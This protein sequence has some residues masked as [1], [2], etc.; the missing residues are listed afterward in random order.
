M[1]RFFHAALAGAG[2]CVVLVGDTACIRDTDCGICDPDNLIVESI[3]G[4][5][6]ASKKVHLLGPD[7]EGD[8]CPGDIKS[9]HYFVEEIKPCEDTDEAKE[10]GRPDEYCKVWPLAVTFGVEFIFN[11]LL[12]PTSVELVRKRPDQPKLFEVYDWKPDVVDIVGPTTRYNGDF[13]KGASEEPDL[14]TRLVNLACVDNLREAGIDFGAVQNQDPVNNPCNAV[15]DV[16]GKLVP[17]KM[18]VD[19]PDAKLQ[20]YKG[21]WTA[22]T[23]SCDT[24]QDGADT[25]CSEC[26]FLLGVRVAKYGLD[27]AGNPRDVNAGT[28]I[29]CDATEGDSLVDCRNF[30]PSVDR[31]EED[32]TYKYAWADGAVQEWKIAKSDKIRETHPDDRPEGFENFDAPC[33]EDA[34]CR[35]VHELPGTVCIGQKN[36][37]A[38]RADFDEECVENRVCRAEWFV[39]CKQDPNTTGGM[40]G[41]CVDRRFSDAGAAGCYE[42]TANFQGQCDDMGQSCGNY[43]SRKRLANCNSDAND[44]LFAASECCQES[45]GGVDISADEEGIQC[46]PYFQPEI[47]PISVYDRNDTLPGVTRQC[48]CED[49]PPQE[50]ARVVDESCRDADGNIRA[51][52]EG[53]YATLFVE[54]RGGVV[55]DPAIKGVEW[56]PADLGGIPRAD[57]ENCAEGRTQIGARNRHEGWRAN[58]TFLAEAF[59]DFDRAMCSGSTYTVT[60]ATPGDGSY[61]RD[62]VGNSLE[63]KN[64]YTF[65]TPQFHVQPGSGFPTDNLRIGACDNFSIRFSNK[66]DMSPENQQKLQIFRVIKGDDDL[67]VADDTITTPNDDCGEIVPVAGGPGCVNTR[68]ELSPGGTLDPCAAPCLVTDIADQATGEIRVSVDPAEFGPVL[69]VQETYRVVVPGL[70]DIEQMNDPNLYRSAFWDACGMPLVVGGQASGTE[71]D[72]VYQFTIDEPK[73]KEDE[74]LDTVQ[75]SCDNAPDIFNPDQSDIDGDGVGDVVDLCPT[76]DTAVANTA[77][78]DKDGVGNECDNCRQT[79]KQYN[80]IDP[81]VSIDAAYLVRNVPMQGDADQDG[82]GDVCDNCVMQ[83]NC[84]DFGPD[85][86]YEVGTAILYNDKNKCQRDDD[87]DLVGDVCAAAEPLPNAAGPVGFGAADDFDQDG[88]G[89]MI[90][91]CP[92]QPVEFIDCSTDANA[93]PEFS[94]CETATGT[95]N[96]VDYDGDT[97]GDVCDTCPFTAN[98][99]QITDGGMQ[100]DDEDGD[101]VGKVCEPN[102]ACGQFP[103]AKPYSFYQVS[104]NDYCCTAALVADMATGDLLNAITGLPLKDPDGLPIRVDCVEPDDPEQRTCRS[105]P[106]Q[107][108][109]APGILTPPPGCDLALEAAG[110]TAQTN[111]RLTPVDVPDLVQ[112]WD[113]MCFLPVFDQDYDGWGDSCDFCPSDFDPENLPFIDANG[114]VWPKDGKYCNGDYSIENKCGGEDTDGTGS[115]SES[116]S[117]SEGGTMATDDGMGTAGETS[118]G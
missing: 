115:G 111:P 33:S 108:R 9:G 32:Y 18:R 10:S 95:C 38:C 34:D 102:N 11:N 106:Q 116:G 17:W 35:D 78:S 81:T 98:G 82:I 62:K 6:Y 8:R 59:E 46:D 88:L 36:G 66:Y 101:F 23:S 31:Q 60:F 48:V 56:R 91:G 14:I 67:S 4:H 69:Q 118:G 57:V 90:D 47:R 21:L 87:Q 84:E 54:R 52:R 24:P 94:V 89:N 19:T 15:R 29:A 70:N 39:G 42:A 109:D 3:S 53:E 74:D 72:F 117:G 110:L 20:S 83:P 96:H 79:I 12:E 25:C 13:T 44:T 100:D 51:D 104:V 37:A 99:E 26:D 85:N 2:L 65:E 58:D 93:C 80:D 71:P 86:P 73:C 7:C 68:D 64:E 107:L 61:L 41:Y 113:S 43:K 55:Y 63:G 40:Q 5:N 22:G 30:V 1:P 76:I 16:D 105:L 97:V 27:E 45:L 28:A 50:C 112:L 77:D 114:R 103:R 75:L 92:R 49:D